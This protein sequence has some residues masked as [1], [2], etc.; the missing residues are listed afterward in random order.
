MNAQPPSERHQRRPDYGFTTAEPG[1]I[2]D[3]RIPLGAFRGGQTPRVRAPAE[4]EIVATHP[5]EGTAIALDAG[6]PDPGLSWSRIASDFR[7]QR[8]RSLYKDSRRRILVQGF[9]PGDIETG[10]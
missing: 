7:F 6:D 1:E 10:R 8:Q 9:L 3:G 4:P 2:A 5:A